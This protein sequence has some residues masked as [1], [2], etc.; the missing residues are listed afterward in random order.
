[1]HDD[2][3]ALVAQAKYMRRLR[4]VQCWKLTNVGFRSLED[5]PELCEM[6]VR[7]PKLTNACLETFLSMPKLVQLDLQDCDRLTPGRL[8]ELLESHPTLLQIYHSG[9]G[10]NPLGRDPG[11]DER[12][13]VTPA[14]TDD[15]L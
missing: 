3:V 6:M 4:L 11:I 1:M 10:P 14:F 13:L 15:L 5:A 9:G 8:E 7:A 2:E 12:P